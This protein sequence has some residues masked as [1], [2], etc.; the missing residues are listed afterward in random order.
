AS[1]NALISAADY[2]ETMWP[3]RHMDRL[4]TVVYLPPCL[5]FLLATLKLSAWTRLRILVAYGGFALTLL[6]IPLM[7]IFVVG[8]QDKAPEGVYAG[9]LLVGALIGCLDGIGQGALY[10][11]AALLPPEYTH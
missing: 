8:N 6:V 11:E 9:T 1:W 2:T 3:G 7:D 10:G 5:F 4:L